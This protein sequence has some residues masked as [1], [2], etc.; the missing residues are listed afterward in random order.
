MDTN[1]LKPGGAVRI[2]SILLFLLC[3][4]FTAWSQS[5]Q[6][7]EEANAAYANKTYD[8]AISTYEQLL[9][10]GYSSDI[11]H[12]NLGNAYFRTNHLGKAILHY[13]KALQLAPSDDD[14]QHNLEVA[15][16]LQKDEME[17]L[18]AF[19]LSSWWRGLRSQLST[20]SW[21]IFGILLLWVAAGGFLLW[22]LGKER[23]QRKRGFLVG[24]IALVLC[25]LPFSLAIS[26]KS[27]DQHSKEAVVLAREA[28]LHFAPDTDSQVVLNIHEG[29]KVDLQD[30]IS[31][32]YKVRLPNGEVGWL[33]VEV[34]AEI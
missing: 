7:M 8:R 30:R 9:S 1:A 26:R 3:W 4:Q 24:V 20:N 6:L 33:P 13:E 22:L 10:D 18:P 11:L 29:L 16:A 2:G 28:Q 5:S 17:P 15:Y 27:F 34:V 23:A 32:W 25:A 31:D 12:Y 19:F 14:I 21:T